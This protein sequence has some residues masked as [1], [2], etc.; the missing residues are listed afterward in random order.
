M[1][2]GTKTRRTTGA[3]QGRFG[4]TAG[5]PQGRFARS[6]STP[7]RSNPTQGLRRRRP[8]EPSG[9][10]KVIGA[11]IPASAAK[12]AAPSSKKGKAGALALVAGAAGM[13]FKNR[14]KLSELRRKGSDVDTTATSAGNGSTANPSGPVAP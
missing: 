13:A 4:R 6:A 3:G 14:D 1:A 10:K 7:R 12:K 8:P 2:A 9:V 5:A 11:M